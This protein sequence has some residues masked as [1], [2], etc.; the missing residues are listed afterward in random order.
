VEVIDQEAIARDD[1]AK[2]WLEQTRARATVL[3]EAHRLRLTG[4]LWWANLTF[5]VFPAVLSTGAAIFAARPDFTIK[6]IPPASVMA[7][8]AAVLLAIHKALKCDEY[9]EEC[10]RLSQRYD[11]VATSADSAL[12]G[13]EAEHEQV[14]KDLTTELIQDAERQLRVTLDARPPTYRTIVGQKLASS[15]QDLNR[16]TSRPSRYPVSTSAAASA[17]DS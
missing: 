1:D 2:A 12:F 10:L 5:V 6:S 3:A 16:G 9:Q 17:K 8:V 15:A 14:R 4:R 7:G 13:P 11:A